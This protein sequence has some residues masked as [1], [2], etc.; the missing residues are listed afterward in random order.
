MRLLKKLTTSYKALSD[1]NRILIYQMGKVGSTSLERSI[2]GAVQLH[3][4]YGRP[5]CHLHEKKLRESVVGRV[6][7]MFRDAFSRFAINRRPRIRIITLIRN[8]LDRNISMFF[9]D[10]VFWVREYVEN[11]KPDTREEGDDFL[12][13]AFYKTFDHYYFERWFDN[14]LK[15]FTGIDLLDVASEQS[16]VFR[17][18]KGKFDIL[19]LRME[20]L[21]SGEAEA[22]LEEYC[23]ERIHLTTDNAGENKW[24][25]D[26]YRRVKSAI[27]SDIAYQADLQKTRFSQVLYKK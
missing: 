13:E 26:V 14:E 23:G 17:V 25:A 4:L 11:Y 27:Y 21:A 16:E 3:S 15:R 12:I 2:P 9:Q 24:Y 1:E 6:W 10:L 22:L 20:T 18:Q 5:P 8:P 19:F 7:I